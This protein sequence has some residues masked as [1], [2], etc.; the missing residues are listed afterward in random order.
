MFK[1]E[2]TRVDKD[3]TSQRRK[4]QDEILESLKVTL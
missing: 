4:K 1:S 2:D 3:F